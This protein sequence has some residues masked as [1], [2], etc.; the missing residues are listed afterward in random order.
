[1]ECRA[2]ASRTRSLALTLPRPAVADGGFESPKLARR[3]PENPQLSPRHQPY[4]GVSD[5][6]A[7]PEPPGDFG[8]RYARVEPE[9]RRRVSQVVGACGEATWAGVSA[10]PHASFHRRS[11]TDSDSGPPWRP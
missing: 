7:V 6:E 2:G 9:R 1:M 3:F 4:A 8:R 11:Y 10:Y 5:R